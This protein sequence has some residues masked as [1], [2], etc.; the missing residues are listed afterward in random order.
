MQSIL[1]KLRLWSEQIPKNRYSQI[2]FVCLAE[3]SNSEFDLC[4][5]SIK[6]GWRNNASWSI[7]KYSGPLTDNFDISAR[8]N[9][10]ILMAEKISRELSDFERIELVTN[11]N[12][13]HQLLKVIILQELRDSLFG[14]YILSDGT[15]ILDKIVELKNLTNKITPSLVASGTP[16]YP[17]MLE[18]RN[19]PPSD[20]DMNDG[21]GEIRR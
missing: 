14:R 7:F 21:P 6:F 12:S 2:V 15:H 3:D 4:Q 9:L 5:P 17:D 20:P 19:H 10:L 18:F 16:M 8:L 11:D 1:N 13:L